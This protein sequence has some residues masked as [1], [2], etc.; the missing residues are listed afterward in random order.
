MKDRNG[1]NAFVHIDGVTYI[2]GAHLCDSVV[3]F[4]RDSIK[5]RVEGAG[6]TS[7]WSI[8]SKGEFLFEN[9]HPMAPF[10]TFSHNLPHARAYLSKPKGADEILVSIKAAIDSTD[11]GKDLAATIEEQVKRVIADNKLATT[12]NNMTVQ[13]AQVTP[14][15]K[16]LDDLAGEFL[17]PYVKEGTVTDDVI[18][19]A[20]RRANLRL[21]LRAQ[22]K[23]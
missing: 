3:S 22:Y 16:S 13:G 4:E 7:R 1:N 6:P 5:A 11:L 19:E 8:T 15:V 17:A 23:G 12:I 14:T 20:Y 18:R 10:F 2:S 9:W 21:S